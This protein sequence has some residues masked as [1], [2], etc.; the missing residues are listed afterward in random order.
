MI[1]KLSKRLLVLMKIQIYNS[2]QEGMNK[3]I[4]DCIPEEKVKW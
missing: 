2:I 1:G 3:P 4:K